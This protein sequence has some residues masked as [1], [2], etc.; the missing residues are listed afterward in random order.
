MDLYK[1]YKAR[2]TENNSYYL[3][4]NNSTKKQKF[5]PKKKI[6]ITENSYIMNNSSGKKTEITKK[7][8]SEFKCIKDEKEKLEKKSENK[9]EQLMRYL[10]IELDRAQKLKKV[11]EKLTEKDKKIKKFIKV[12][13][14][15]LKQMEN[16]R[17]QDHQDV[18]ER[19]KLYEKMLS[20]Y[21]Q[22]VY[23]TKQQY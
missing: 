15:G 23:L 10:K 19:Q 4:K 7:E 21:D 20:N 11:K 14:E 16:E 1:R 17:Y 5:V 18:Y 2:K 6:R 13:N 8:L 12:K 3:R 22:K 9:D